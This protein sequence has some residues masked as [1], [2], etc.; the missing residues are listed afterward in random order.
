MD[1]WTITGE[2]I[3][4]LMLRFLNEGVVDK[5][6]IVTPSKWDFT[7]EVT[8]QQMFQQMQGK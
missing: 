8:F 3:H 6:K 5:S 1:I 4:N 7:P 2:G